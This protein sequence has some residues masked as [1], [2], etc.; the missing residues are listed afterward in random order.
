MFFEKVSEAVR[1]MHPNVRKAGATVLIVLAAAGFFW[2]V[3]KLRAAEA[4]A[5]GA[6]PAARAQAPLAVQAPS[7][8]V[9]E[10]QGDK[11]YGPTEPRAVARRWCDALA[12]Q[13]PDAAAALIGGPYAKSWAE[14]FR[15]AEAGKGPILRVELDY[16]DEARKFDYTM[17][18]SLL[19]PEDAR[20]E[21]PNWNQ[22]YRVD[23][24]RASGVSS[25]FI[26]V[27]REHGPWQVVYVGRQ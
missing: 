4:P 18:S 19:G 3:N 26:R 13:G 2:G 7:A 6:A 20:R 15:R 12:R 17:A 21:D 11:P 24:V 9:R 25:W 10:I 1:K 16:R 22:K 23:I 5:P 8:P 14:E 27:S